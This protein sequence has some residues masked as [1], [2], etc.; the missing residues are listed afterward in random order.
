MGV[1]FLPHRA[2]AMWDMLEEVRARGWR[3][4]TTT[5][6]G[7]GPPPGSFRVRSHR[8]PQV[9]SGRSTSR[10]K[11]A[12]EQSI[13]AYEPGKPSGPGATSTPAS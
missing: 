11:L 4:G 3:R 7:R 10:P 6:S 8:V 9:R 12:G 5:L 2:T 13:G 1:V